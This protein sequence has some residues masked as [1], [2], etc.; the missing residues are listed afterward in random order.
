MSEKTSIGN[1]QIK[2]V[3]LFWSL[4]VLTAGCGLYSGVADWQ[5][6]QSVG[7]ISIGS[8]AKND[9]GEV[10][11]PVECGLAGL[12]TV[13]IKPTAINSTYGLKKYKFKI[14]QSDIYLSI[15]YG[16]GFPEQC[17]PLNLGKLPDGQYQLFY[18]AK[19]QKNFIGNILV[20]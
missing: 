11:V 10:I 7:G 18:R 5:F 4:I 12:N 16:A 20:K 13:T 14:K 19:G 17:T 3:L 1:K 6:I 2:V 8:T 15:V 9:Q